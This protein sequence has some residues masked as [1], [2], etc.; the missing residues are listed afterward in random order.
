MLAHAQLLL[1]QQ[2]KFSAYCGDMLWLHIVWIG[3]PL[4]CCWIAKPLDCWLLDN[5]NTYPTYANTFQ[6]VFMRFMRRE[7]FPCFRCLLLLVEGFERH[8]RLVIAERTRARA[9]NIQSVRVLLQFAIFRH[10]A[11]A[12]TFGLAWCTSWDSHVVSTRALVVIIIVVIGVSYHRRRRRRCVVARLAVC[13]HPS[14]CPYLVHHS[15]NNHRSHHHCRSTSNGFSCCESSR[16]FQFDF[17]LHTVWTT[18]T[19]KYRE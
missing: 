4:Q 7:P 1:Q 11:T 10:E 12:R 17:M 18:T 19:Q 6:R 14:L 9:F 15:N 8:A 5:Q 3:W 16:K 2:R 13:W